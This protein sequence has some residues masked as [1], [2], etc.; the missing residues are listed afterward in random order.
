MATHDG[1]PT[2]TASPL[3]GQ[4][5]LW[6]H[7]SLHPTF[8]PSSTPLLPLYLNVSHPPSRFIHSSMQAHLPRLSVPLSLDFPLYLSFP[9]PLF[10]LKLFV[11]RSF[12]WFHRRFRFFASPRVLVTRW[13]ICR[14]SPAIE[15]KC[16]F[17]G[18]HRGSI[19]IRAI[20]IS[21]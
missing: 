3:P 9:S 15:F 13:N 19:L 20:Y 6:R 12:V 18:L 4:P 16:R 21:I 14:F 11:I 10:F 5:Q 17:M 1:V 7:S 8:T 2:R